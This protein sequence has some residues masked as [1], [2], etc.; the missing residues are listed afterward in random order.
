MYGQTV[1]FRV[2][3]TFHLAIYI[4]VFAAR[5]FPMITTDLPM[6]VI[7]RGGVSMSAPPAKNTGEKWILLQGP[8]LHSGQAV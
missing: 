7:S 3:G 4:K 5:E 6:R 1:S 8:R 2:D